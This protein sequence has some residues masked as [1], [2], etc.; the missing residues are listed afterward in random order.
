[1]SYLIWLVMAEVSTHFWLDLLLLG[2]GK[3]PQRV[4]PPG[5]K[6]FN[7][8]VYG[9]HFIIQTLTFLF[10]LLKSNGYLRIQITPIL[11]ILGVVQKSKCEG[12]SETKGMDVIFRK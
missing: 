11:R 6:M 2:Q 1:M 7:T 10:W 8:Q 5:T 4:L 3:C 9:R 12:V